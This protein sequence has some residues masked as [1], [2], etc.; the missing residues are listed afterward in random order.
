MDSACA[1]IARARRLT[2]VSRSLG[3]SRAQ[4]SVRVRRRPDWQDGC[5]QRLSD[6]REVLMRIQ[7]VIAGYLPTVIVVSGRYCGVSLSPKD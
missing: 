2:A 3:V 5:K 4:L 6:D 1:L 7:R